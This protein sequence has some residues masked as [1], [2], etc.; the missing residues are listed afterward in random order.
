MEKDTSIK[1][2]S[3]LGTLNPKDKVSERENYWKLI[4]EKGKVINTVENDNGRVLVL[5][6]KNLDEFKV[7]NHNPIKNSLWIKKNRF[8]SRNGMTKYGVICL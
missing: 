7:E 3:F 4:G 2:K 6:D 5:F 8:G 1:L